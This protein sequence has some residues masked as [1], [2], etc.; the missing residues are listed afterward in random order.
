MIF[1]TD[2]VGVDF[3]LDERYDLAITEDGDIDY[4]Q[5][6]ETISSAIIRRV[7]TDLNL[8]QKYAR[9]GSR[10]YSMN[11]DY[12]SRLSYYLS[13]P[14]TYNDR[15]KETIESAAKLDNRVNVQNVRLRSSRTST[16]QDNKV[17]IEL[18]YNIEPQYLNVRSESYQQ[19]TIPYSI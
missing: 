17:D 9:V 6:I 14:S 12:G 2:K 11:P 13:S 3:K 5:G 7:S 1:T 8:Y 15:I 10:I 4:T 19:L 18:T 16:V